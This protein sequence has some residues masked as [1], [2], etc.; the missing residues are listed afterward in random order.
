MSH[1]AIRPSAGRL[2]TA[3]GAVVA[4]CALS[5]AAFAATSTTAAHASPAI[6]TCT[7]A[8]DLHLRIPN[9]KGSKKDGITYYTLDFTN[10]SS[11][12]CSLSGFPYVSM[13]TKAGR[14]LGS[15][16]SHARMTVVPLVRLAPGA[17]AHTTLAYY[18]GKVSGSSG[19]GPVATAFE[20]RAYVAGQKRA[21]YTAL[22]LHSCSRSGRVYLLITQSFRSG[23]GAS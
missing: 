19:C 9:T 11:S 7:G 2:V 5:L 12:T 6:S 17:T 8:T 16:A 22:G 14:Q 18:G 21:L 13:V 1:L 10:T 23:A 4:T 20:L 3:A 15:P